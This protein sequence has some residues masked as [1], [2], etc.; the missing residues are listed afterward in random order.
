MPVDNTIHDRLSHTW[1][2]EDGFLNICTSG[3]NPARFGYMKRIL[4]EKLGTDPHGLA[5]VAR[6]PTPRWAAE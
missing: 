4:T 1:W 3:L 6:S 5:A 2:E